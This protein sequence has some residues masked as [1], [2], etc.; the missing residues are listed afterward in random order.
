MAVLVRLGSI[1]PF[2]ITVFL[3]EVQ[4]YEYF[5]DEFLTNSKKA[6]WKLDSVDTP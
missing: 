5:V 4:Y 6:A 3:D 1:F 2:F